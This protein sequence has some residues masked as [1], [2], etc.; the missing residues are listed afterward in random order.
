MLKSFYRVPIIFRTNSIAVMITR[1]TA[2][3]V[4]I[5]SIQNISNIF[6]INNNSATITKA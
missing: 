6:R 4:S 1:I 2:I 5:F 3:P